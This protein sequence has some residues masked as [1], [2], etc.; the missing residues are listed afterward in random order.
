MSGRRPDTFRF[1]APFGILVV[2]VVRLPKSTV[3]LF[4]VVWF[5]FAV[6]CWSK[7]F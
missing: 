1:E 4:Q 7:S 5:G 2:V 3:L 6:K